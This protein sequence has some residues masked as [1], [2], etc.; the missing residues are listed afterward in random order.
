MQI[1]KSVTQSQPSGMAFLA[2]RSQLFFL[3]RRTRLGVGRTRGLALGT[4][5]L[6]YRRHALLGLGADADRVLPEDFAPRQHRDF[7]WV[8]ARS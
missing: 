6:G 2:S 4:G 5:R 1:S 3:G 7:A 8:T